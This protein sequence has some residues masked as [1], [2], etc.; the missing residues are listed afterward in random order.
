VFSWSNGD[1][2]D[3]EWVQ[4]KKEGHGV[5]TWENKD[6]YDGQWVTDKKTGQGRFTWASGDT[7][8]GG[9]LKNKKNGTGVYT[10]TNGDTF[11][12]EWIKGQQTGSGS[13]RWGNKN[14]FTGEW[15]NGE[16]VEGTFAEY[17]TGRVFVARSND[18]IN[19]EYLDPALQECINN[20]RCT[21]EVTGE[22]CYFQYLWE[23]RENVDRTHGVCLACKT[24]CV[25]ANSIKL[26]DPKKHH[27]GGNF[28]CD[29]GS[30]HLPLPCTLSHSAHADAEE[31]QSP[32]K[33]PHEQ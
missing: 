4:N 15:K 13:N 32:R 5:F 12:G 2:Y 26:L 1:K 33:V 6:C 16:K 30:G 17:P 23:T 28:F 24:H 25:P 11:E 14:V 10:W 31:V 27:F 3:G 29:C 7:Y 19:L 18:L 8:T 20:K 21:Y 9:W 22:K